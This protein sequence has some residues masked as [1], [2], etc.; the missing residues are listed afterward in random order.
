MPIQSRNDPI[1]IE[2]IMERCPDEKILADKP[3]IAI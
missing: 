1:K 2:N 3:V